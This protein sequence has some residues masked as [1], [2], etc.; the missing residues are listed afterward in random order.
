MRPLLP[1]NGPA[2][3][4]TSRA[5]LVGLEGAHQVDLDVFDRDD[6][7]TLLT[8]IAG[9]ERVERDRAAAERVVEQCG[10]LP[11]AVRIAGARLAARPH[12]PVSRLQDLLDDERRRLDHLAVADF[13]VRASVALSYR[14][15]PHR[16]ARAFRLL[17]LV[18]VDDFPAWVVGAL[19]D[20]DA[21]TGEEELERL[22]EAQLVEVA[23]LDVSGQTRYRFHDLIRLYAA[24]LGR[25]EEPGAARAALRRAFDGWL[26]L[27]AL[28]NSR[29][30]GPELSAAAW[31][32]T[33]RCDPSIEAVAVGKPLAWFD[34]ELRCLLGVV[35]QASALGLNAS[36]WPLAWRMHL[37]L[38]IRTLWNEWR[39][40][41][42]ESLAA[43]RRA[44]DR[45][46]EAY[47]LLGLADL[48]FVTNQHDD[49]ERLPDEALVVANAAGDVWAR[50]L[51]LYRVGRLA[52][53]AKRRHAG[54]AALQGGAE[55]SSPGRFG[56]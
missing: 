26:G 29:L 27:A 37:Y 49:A 15:L 28:A 32:G 8:R 56:P 44:G 53:G 38:E 31:P 1:G 40:C 43:A 42:E 4:V 18:A 55:A 24:E 34:A 14:A 25:E 6:A 7:V 54:S 39:T 13:D 35:G 23:G 9:S 11:L 30:R 19:L 52:Q 47:M 48:A 21:M 33:V 2:V 3:V 16:A 46:G 10:L 12:W 17:G 36:C 41:H 22:V 50:G 20:T 45:S 51:A 5:R